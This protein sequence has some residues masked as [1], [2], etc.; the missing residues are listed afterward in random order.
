MRNS[1][2]SQEQGSLTISKLA[3]RLTNVLI[4]VRHSY[5]I[6]KRLQHKVSGPELRLYLLVLG[7]LLII[8][9]LSP[10]RLDVQGL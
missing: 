3:R 2:G 7:D 9:I 1:L 8:L 10:Y 6:M 4:P 5:A